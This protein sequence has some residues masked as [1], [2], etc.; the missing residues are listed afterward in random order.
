MNRREYAE[1]TETEKKF[2]I[3]EL[4]VKQ[5]FEASL[6]HKAFSIALYNANRKK[7]KPALP[8]WEKKQTQHSIKEFNEA[9]EKDM[10]SVSTK[11]ILKAL[12]GDK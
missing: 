6:M 8:L 3:K 2:I 1:L 5:K 7:N 10:K 9:A 11:N 12:R 4:Q